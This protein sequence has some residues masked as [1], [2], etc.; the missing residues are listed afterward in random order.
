M[1]VFAGLV[2]VDCR[3]VMCGFICGLIIRKVY[4]IYISHLNL[5]MILE[6]LIR[7]NV[8]WLL[9]SKTPIRVITPEHLRVLKR[10]F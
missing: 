6:I 3:I 4:E 1:M 9:T 7:I 2:I 5:F 10:K 8:D